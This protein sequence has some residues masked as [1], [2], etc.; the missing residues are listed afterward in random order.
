VTGPDL[1]LP[2]L[3]PGRVRRAALEQALRD[4]VRA[5]RLR[6]CA[7]LPS[8]R[9]LAAELRCSRRLV[10]EAY[11]QLVAEG[12]LVAR[13]GSGTR[14]AAGATAAAQ[15]AAP[16]HATPPPPRIDL[17]PGSPDLSL[18]PRRAWGRALRTALAEV[19]DAELGYGP[20]EGHPRLR[21]ALAEH[22]GRVRGALAE[23]ATVLVTSGYAGGLRLV[24]GVLR[25]RGVR[26]VGVEDP[27]Y[28][29]AA[30]AVARAGLEVVPVPADAQGMDVAALRRADPDA[31]IVSPAHGFPLGGVLAPERRAALLDWSRTRE[32]LLIDDDYDAELRYDREPVGTLQGL[33]PDRVVLAGTTSKVL[34]PALRL[35]WLVAPPALVGP[36]RAAALVEEHGGPTLEQ[37]ALAVLFESGAVDRH[38]RAGRTR[39]RARRAALLAALAERLP[40]CP[41]GGIDAG[42]R[43]WIAL[44]DGV[45]EAALAAAA[46][47]RG[48][49]VYPLASSRL[50]RAE[51]RGLVLGYANASERELREA[52]DVLAAALSSSGATRAPAA[53]A[54]RSG[55]GSRSPGRRPPG[56]R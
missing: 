40:E 47:R 45:D 8:S 5:G 13:H 38:V 29:F 55:P 11:G 15:R 32:S 33:A 28:Q 3:A 36:L 6:P 20:P 23:P 21:A 24:L 56:R 25:E 52:V 18:F 12:F 53:A 19:P 37:V 27:G 2:A 26:S 39:Y 7:R 43:L 44:P 48:V 34:A 4:A 50:A 30:A 54:P 46:E 16:A 35:G 31:A 14:V 9:A 42:L 1:L 51:P 22:L 17:F 49:R 10:A 41:V